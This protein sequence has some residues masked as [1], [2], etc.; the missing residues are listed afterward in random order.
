MSRS[1]IFIFLVISAAV[2]AYKLPS[3]YQATDECDDSPDGTD[4]NGGQQPGGG[5]PDY[6]YGLKDYLGKPYYYGAA[7]GRTGGSHYYPKRC[8]CKKPHKKVDFGKL[9][10]L[11]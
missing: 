11:Q 1:I 3:D 9:L 4:Y 7:G 6:G 2:T 8:P 5:K 10:D